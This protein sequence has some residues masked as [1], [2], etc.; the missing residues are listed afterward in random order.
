MQ[1]INGTN[2]VSFQEYAQ[3]KGKTVGRIYQLKSELPVVKFDDLGVELINYDLLQLSETEVNL[4]Q[5]KFQTTQA[6]HTYDH[7]Q[8]S[9]FFADMIKGNFEA[10]SNV[11][12]LLREKELVLEE[13]SKTILELSEKNKSLD[14]LLSQAQEEHLGLTESLQEKTDALEKAD[15]LIVEQNADLLALTADKSEA[16]A[17][18]ESL[19]LAQQKLQTDFDLK[20]AENVGLIKEQTFAVSQMT[21]LNKEIEKL[22][23]GMES[24]NQ[25]HQKV[26]GQKE[27]L[28]VLLNETKTLQ[29]KTLHDLELKGFEIQGLMKDNTLLQSQVVALNQKLQEEQSFNQR[30]GKLEEIL[31]KEGGKV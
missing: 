10:R 31:L 25:E 12:T 23:K 27:D 5:S 28:N 21:G 6:L 9:L 1:N 13:Q 7:K 4:A 3:I 19:K 18:V 24:L 11:E 26:L 30:L 22:Q 16:L 17:L 14:A 8:L 20:A 2:Y 29:Q 15:A